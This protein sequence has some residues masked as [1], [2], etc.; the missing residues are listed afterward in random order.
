M[1]QVSSF[2]NDLQMTLTWFLTLKCKM[3]LNEFLLQRNLFK[4]F[5]KLEKKIE[6]VINLFT[7]FAECIY[8]TLF[9]YWPAF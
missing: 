9:L 5:D 4:P 3:Q 7:V 8:V 2:L 1:L 6:R